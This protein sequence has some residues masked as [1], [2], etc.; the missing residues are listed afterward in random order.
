MVTNTPETARWSQPRSLSRKLV[1]Y[2][3]AATCAL[4]V[5]TMWVSYDTARR[6]LQD[7]TR[8]EAIKQVQATA[9]TF[10]SY[11]DRVAVLIRGIAA[12]Q[13]SIGRE[14]DANTISYLSHL[15]DTISP[16]EAY[17]VYVAFGHADGG[18]RAMQWV[19]R[20]SQPDPVPTIDDM[21]DSRLE[22]YQG[23]VKSGKL[24]VSEPFFDRDGSRTLLL[25]V[26]KPFFDSDNRRVGIVGA[27]LS[28][29]LIQAIVSQIRFRPGTDTGDYAFLISRDGKMISH[30]K[31]D[32]VM[33]KDAKEF[34][35]GRVAL[36]KPEGF[37][38]VGEAG[39]RRHLFWS[40][41]PLTGW[42]VAIN[43]PES[44]ILAP[45]REL[46]VR[47]AI[48]AAVSVAGMIV[49]V[50]LVARRVIDPVRRLTDV[51]AE[52]AAQ[53]Y[54]RVGELAASARRVD[55]LGQ[56]A[57]GFQT[58]VREVSSREM[59]LKQ[60]EERLARS[61]MYFRSLI[62]STSDVVAIFD[63]NGTVLYASPSC[64]RVLGL[65]PGSYV[66]GSGFATLLR[67]DAATAAEALRRVVARP[68]GVQRVE[69]KSHH[70]DGSI[71][72][73]EATLH[74]LLGNPAVAGVVVN[75]R[76]ATERKQMEGLTKEKEAA[77]A[78]S[79]AK[80]AFLASMSH[81]LRT[82]LNAIIGYSEMLTDEAESEGLDS[83]VPDLGKIRSAGKHLLELINAVLDISKIEAG[84][85]ELYLETFPVDKMVQDV[86]AIIQPLAQ[87]RT[88]KLV[89]SIGSS[90]G[91]MHA[92]NTKVR[93]A[94]FNLL[95]NACKFTEKGTVTLEAERQG[96]W[97]EFRV[98]D[99]G[100]GMTPEQSAKLFQ[101]FTQADASIS[102]KFGGTG[103]GLAISQHFCHMMGGN[104]SVTSEAGK[105]T[106]F[107]VRLPAQVAQASGGEGQR[108]TIL[109][110]DDDVTVHDLVRRVV[111]KEGY[112]V[113]AAT[114]GEDGLRLARES[115]PD[116]V[117]LDAMMPGMDGW[118]T[119]GKFKADAALNGIP[120][121]ML[122]IIDDKSL[123]YS[124]GASDY[125]TKPL[126]RERLLATVTRLCKSR[127]E[128][129]VVDSDS[130]TRDM[131]V[132]TLR[133]DGWSVLPA[134]SCAAAIER[135]ETR[136]P[137]VVVL[138]LT[139]PAGRDL[140]QHLRKDGEWSAIPVVAI[141]NGDS[142]GGEF[143][144]VLRKETFSRE[145]LLR[146][147]RLA[148]SAGPRK[149]YAQTTAG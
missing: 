74:N 29:G 144:G 126:D 147:T 3:V 149:Q 82:P 137:A 50:L 81:E 122:T 52:V 83:F 118:S 16:E 38:V 129:L 98:T 108:G 40:T 12:R 56:L 112:R 65:A 6:R 91:S 95:S 99:T 46:A 61:E 134:E 86:A 123:A 101:A 22:W 66:G 34:G 8:S 19:D 73:V 119:L 31:M 94:L 24:H 14:P 97:F 148:P 136:T 143:A 145:D 141:T 103:L 78:A 115:R 15:L 26:T 33:S 58:M 114:N 120:I 68:N 48:A 89:V 10:D 36:E 17:G 107:F 131:V 20:L 49:L 43:I 130:A 35:E 32:G 5:A 113:V 59:Q 133:S 88:N 117:T 124:L 64:E 57:R 18:I 21:R 69:L 139:G 13:E 109:V 2:I 28:L 132:R 62:E 75:F 72:I 100:I 63:A 1:L 37:A 25:S 7:Q 127:G 4:L 80:S 23:P 93:Q 138:D 142:D 67:N 70:P 111:A 79:K 106:S 85:M 104:I 135:L 11:V 84:K 121:V 77:E 76:D 110:I 55:E 102:G 30:P 105:G 41:A 47:S 87:K 44:V 9:S 116:L 39:A 54:E 42:K 92:D 71:R 53:N 125:L 146:L 128:A 51:T 27:D 90:L 60:A 140:L 45:A 96:D